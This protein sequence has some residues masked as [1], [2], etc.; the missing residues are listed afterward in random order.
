MRRMGKGD[1]PGDSRL[2]VLFFLSGC[3]VLG[4][5]AGCVL[6]SYLGQDAGSSLST[7]LD[8]YFQT[9]HQGETAAF[10]LISVFWEIFR[11]PFAVLAFSLT[12]IGAIAI[13][14]VFCVR[15]FL[16]S[17]SVSVFVQIYGING[18]PLALSVF[19]LP[20]ALSITALFIIGVDGFSWGRSLAVCLHD[21]GKDRDVLRKR[22]MLRAGVVFCWLTVGVLAQ[23]WVSPILLKIA[24]SLLA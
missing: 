22:L 9:L 4:M 7:Y 10:S 2:P 12:A 14:T 18:L 13:P 24:V 1:G 8:G 19:G 16:L 21:G 6:A 15:G 20:A 17:Y 11:W 5:T 3:F 23:Y